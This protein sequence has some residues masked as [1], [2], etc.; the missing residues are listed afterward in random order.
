MKY[1]DEVK[2]W[3]SIPESDFLPEDGKYVKLKSS[4]A[5]GNPGT[6]HAVGSDNWGG[7]ALSLSIFIV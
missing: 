1:D 3:V 5:S 7:N 4:D 2:T 6:S